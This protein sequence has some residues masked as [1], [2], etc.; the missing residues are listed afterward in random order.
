MKQEKVWDTIAPTWN[1]Y[2]KKPSIEVVNFLKGKEGKILDLGCGSGRNFSSFSKSSHIYAVDFSK[3]MLKLAK[4]KAENLRLKIESF[5]SSSNKIPIKD[6]FFDSGICIAVLHCI[7]T[8]KAREK[9]IDELYRVL[10]P[11]VEALIMVWSKNSPRLKNKPK[12]NF[13]PWT[14]AGVEKRYN[15]TYDKKELEQEVFG[16][17]FEIVNSKENK[18]IILTVRKPS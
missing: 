17:G 9:M 14:S 7:Q 18:N 6:N 12:E 15:Y 5:H 13:I 8:K 4:I 3:E 10:K 11:G 16:A 1:E 2:R